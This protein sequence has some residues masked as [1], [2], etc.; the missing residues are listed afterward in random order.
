MLYGEW[1]DDELALSQ[2]DSA[3]AHLRRSHELKAD[4][5]T[6]MQRLAELLAKRG[7]VPGAAQV[8]QDFLIASQVP[9]EKEKAQRILDRIGK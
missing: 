3:L 2:D 4:L 6:P 1:A 8:V 9:A 7:D 5:F